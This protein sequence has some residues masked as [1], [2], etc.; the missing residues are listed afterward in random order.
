MLYSSP[1][2]A[3]PLRGSSNWATQFARWSD[4]LAGFMIHHL[5]TVRFG[6]PRKSKRKAG[7]RIRTDDLRITNASLYQLSY[8]GTGKKIKGRTQKAQVKGAESK[9]RRGYE[10]AGEIRRSGE[11]VSSYEVFLKTL[12]SRLVGIGNDEVHC[13]RDSR[14]DVCQTDLGHFQWPSGYRRVPS[15]KSPDSGCAVRRR[16][17]RLVRKRS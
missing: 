11:R 2:S 12:Q 4:E 16:G 1:R 13:W 15:A 3:P 8:P 6:C 10:L 17:I 5:E 9:G 7:N 14:S